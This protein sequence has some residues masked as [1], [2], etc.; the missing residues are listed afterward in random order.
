MSGNH[1][2]GHWLRSRSSLSPEQR[3]VAKRLRH[4]PRGSLLGAFQVG[5]GPSDAED[6]LVPP[7]RESEPIHRFLQELAGGGLEPDLLPKMPGSERWVREPRIPGPG[8]LDP[9]GSLD[10]L[11]DRPGGFGFDG[12]VEVSGGDGRYLD[13]EVDPVEEGARD[14]LPI[15]GDLS[16]GAEAWPAGIAEE[17]ARTRVHPS[18]EKE[19][20]RERPGARRPRH[21]DDPVL[22]RFAERF[23]GVPPELRELVE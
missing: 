18:D 23:N 8:R 14:L 19:A 9:S 3:S 17:A 7:G 16:V 2:V 20:G 13:V 21:A 10:P 22:E 5:D 12:A 6:S 15:S 11:G 4:M 1:L